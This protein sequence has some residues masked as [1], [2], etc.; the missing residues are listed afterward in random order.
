[1]EVRMSIVY[2]LVVVL[3]LLALGAEHALGQ[4]ASAARLSSS[5]DALSCSPAPCV[6]PPT[7]VSFGVD[8][9]GAP[10]ATD[11]SNQGRIAVGSA[12]PECTPQSGLGF[13]LTSD[14]GSNWNSFCMSPVFSGNQEYIPDVD[15]VLGY[16]RYGAA[17][18]GGFYLDNSG[19][20]SFGFEGFQKSSDGVNWSTPKPAVILQDHDPDY[21]WLAVDGSAASPYVNSVYVSCVMVPLN[22]QPYNQLVVAH[23]GD[24]GASWR[25]VDVATMQKAPDRDFFSAMS[26]GKDGAVYLTWMYCNKGPQACDNYKAYMVFSRSSD[27]GNTWSPPKLVAPITLETYVPNTNITVRNTP[28][29]AVDNSNGPHSGNLYVVM[30]NWTGAFMQVV[31]ARSTDGGS[32]WSKPVPVAPGITHDQFLPWI[33]VSP[34]GLVGVSW[35]DRRNDPANIDYQA[36]AAISTDGGQSF[37]TNVQLTSGFSDPNAMMGSSIGDYTGNTWDGPNYFLA[38][39]MDNSNTEYLQDYVGGIRLK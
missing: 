4:T 10:V 31:V 19:R 26:I 18:V 27:G 23:S 34:T 20:T 38:A 16:D 22:N 14:G 6:F 12:N 35:L 9:L 25:Q 17:Y 36:Y 11:P 33:S 29:I 37:Q 28:A 39:W 8:A 32:T 13:Y 21:C 30:Y 15:P 7:Q 24:G 2:R 3:S 5:G 1:M